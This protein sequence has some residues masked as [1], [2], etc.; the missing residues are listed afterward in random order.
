MNQRI[1]WVDD[2]VRE[3]QREVKMWKTMAGASESLVSLRMIRLVRWMERKS[4]PWMFDPVGS[5]SVAMVISLAFVLMHAAY[6]AWGRVAEVDE[7]ERGS[8]GMK[9]C[10]VVVEY[11]NP[12]LAFDSA[13]DVQYA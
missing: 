12:S 8:G 5:I 13:W 7:H 11:P 2:T 4:L 6:S 1:G 10:V 3:E 9:R